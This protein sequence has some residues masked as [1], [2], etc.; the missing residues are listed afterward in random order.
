VLIVLYNFWVMFI[1]YIRY[2]QFVIVRQHYLVRGAPRRGCLQDSSR[3]HSNRSNHVLLLVRE[4]AAATSC[5]AV[6]GN[7]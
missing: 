1:L 3:S 2:K 6:P 7:S 4:I 5:S